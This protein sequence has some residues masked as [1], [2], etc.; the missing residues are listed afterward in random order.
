MNDRHAALLI[1]ASALLLGLASDL[2]LRWIPWGVNAALFV[3]LFVAAS[4]VCS[5]AAGRGIHP[6]A[7]TAALLA[8]FGIVWRDSPVLVALDIALLLVFLPMLA[9]GAREVRLRAAGLTQIG[10]AGIT[11]ALQAVAG[12]PQLLVVDLP[13]S[14]LPRGTAVRSGG[15]ALRG[16]MIATPALLVFGALLISAD[17]AFARVLG[18]LFAF[19][20]AEIALHALVTAAGAAVCAG[21]LRSL[22]LSGRA[23][24]P[25]RPSLLRLPQAETNIA[26]ALIDLLFAAFVL[27]QLRY[28]FGGSDAMRIGEMTYAEYARRGFFELVWVVA[29]VVPMLLVAEWLIDKS[30]ARGLRAFRLL[31]LA[32]IA[33]VL[34]I[35]A[36]AWRRMELYRDEYGLTRLRVFTT[37][38]M[39]WLAVLLVWLALTALTGRRERFAMGA[40]AAAVLTITILH[41]VNP[42]ALIVRTNLARAAAGRRAFDTSYALA[43]SDDAAPEIFSNA[44]AF[45]PRG[46]QQFAKRA[47]PE[48]WRTWNVSRHQAGAESA[49]LATRTN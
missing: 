34:V 9:L 35:A 14:R 6:F 1:A 16:A 45:P 37:A 30:D 13:W 2:L 23:P 28:F 12:L 44:S 31:A 25:Q 19:D 17:A 36:S 11:T 8:A 3:G 5:H 10:L 33:L 41:A 15:V 47:R 21:F 48:G 46:L 26:V 49:A 29:L 32:Q 22:A 27:V 40:L 7:A 20:F 43:L 4:A 38:F 18:D 39:I 42:D 24:M